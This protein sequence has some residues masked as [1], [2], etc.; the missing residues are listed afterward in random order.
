MGD[1]AIR[2]EGLS[3]QYR[4]GER[5]SYKTLRDSLSASLQFKGLRSLFA[6][7]NGHQPNSSNDHG[8]FWAL[9]DVSFE[10]KRGEVVGI[11]G[12]NGAG[13][14]TLLKILCRITE[15]S[16]GYADISGRVGSLLEVGTGFHPELTGRE[17]I[18]LNGAILGMRRIEIQR[19]FDEIVE[20]AEVGKF[21]DMAVKHYSTGMHLRLAFG[22]AAHLNT[23]IL[24]V[25][26][27]L[28]VGDVH[29]QQKCMG[30]MGDVAREGRTVLLVSHSMAAITRLCTKAV[31]LQEGSMV[32]M[33]PAQNVVD[34]YLRASVPDDQLSIPVEHKHNNRPF[35]L[36][37]VALLDNHGRTRQSISSG[38]DLFIELSYEC[39]DQRGLSDVWIHLGFHDSQ[40]LPLFSCISKSSVGAPLTLPPTGS[41]I[42]HIPKFP[43][44]P[45]EY[46]IGLWCKS[47]RK[48]I[49]DYDHLL[50]FQVTEGDFFGTG[51]LPTRHGGMF[52]VEHSWQVKGA[53]AERDSVVEL[54]LR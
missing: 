5:S 38:Q 33:G 19:R 35:R 28:A 1:F 15:P 18:Y 27:V 31:M 24:L 50:K 52:L 51:K 48:S 32:A 26:E 10:I 12:N 49:A 25:D 45:G 47:N 16:R 6:R 34:E 40:G 8:S 30:K 17:N 14:S 7:S 11:I 13:K 53:C 43:L 21:I 37:R 44:L 39:A 29:F 3:K 2:V 36:S 46:L 54:A 20:F 41:L 23:E 9:K 4:I 22:V 42:C